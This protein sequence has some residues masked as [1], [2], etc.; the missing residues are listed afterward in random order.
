MQRH[1]FRLKMCQV[2]R[3]FIVHSKCIFAIGS[4]A[5][6]KFSKIFLF[7]IT[8][9]MLSF[10]FWMMEIRFQFSMNINHVVEYLKY[11]KTFWNGSIKHTHKCAC[12]WF[13]NSVNFKEMEKR[14]YIIWLPKLFWLPTVRKRKFSV[15]LEHVKVKKEICK[16]ILELMHKKKS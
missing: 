9:T 1:Y 2:M 11:N 7:S 6:A 14:T 8:C 15:R 13:W 4:T 5:Y 10:V 3:N 12:H 16:A